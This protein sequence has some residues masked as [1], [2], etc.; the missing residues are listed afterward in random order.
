LAK[1]PRTA[2]KPDAQIGVSAQATEGSRYAG[3]RILNQAKKD[4]AKR[5]AVF[6]TL[7]AQQKNGGQQGLSLLQTTVGRESVSH[8]SQFR[9]PILAGFPTMSLAGCQRAV[10]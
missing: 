5:A 6:M 7:K 8:R 3:C 1:R 2:G 10:R 4:G 9:P